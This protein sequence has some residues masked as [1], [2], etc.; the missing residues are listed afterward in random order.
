[1]TDKNL[2]GIF[3]SGI[4]GFSVFKEVRK[5]TTADIIYYGDCARAP[6]G[7]KSEEEIVSYIK[8]ILL[9]LKEQGVTYFVSA[10]NSMS[11]FT[12]KVLLEDV[13]IDVDHYID[14]ISA[15]EK[16]Q[17]TKDQKVLIVATKA[18]LSSGV[19][20]HIL[21]H[22]NIRYEVYSPVT[23]AGDIEAGDVTKVHR[24]VDEV[25]L[26]ALNVQADSILYAC[27]HYPLVHNLFVDSAKRNH[28]DGLFIDPAAYVGEIIKNIDIKGESSSSFISSKS[29]K[30]FTE[31]VRKF[32]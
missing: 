30:A 19:Y 9:F 15:V 17:F 24:S 6:Y 31:C 1:M 10:C 8:E 14:M 29:T 22:K 25:I 11:V 21:E 5:N 28:W 7:N 20:Q 13:G 12:T 32:K 26:Y 23:L 2:L 27:T 3:D 18:T 16:I 4:G